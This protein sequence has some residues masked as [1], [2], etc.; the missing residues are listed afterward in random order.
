M[1][2]ERD[3]YEGHIWGGGGKQCVDLESASLLV[4]QS[5]AERTSRGTVL[6]WRFS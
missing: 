3:T 4:V 2:Y 1:G 5:S 6:G